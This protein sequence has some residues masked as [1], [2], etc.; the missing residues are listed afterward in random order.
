MATAAAGIAS[1]F[2]SS[3][4]TVKCLRSKNYMFAASSLSQSSYSYSLEP[5]SIGTTI[6][7]HKLW[8]PRITAA[9]AH[10]EAIVAA[11]E[12][13]TVVEEEKEGQ[14][15]VK[16][17]GGEIVDTRTKLY[18][19]NLPYGVDS[20]QLAGLIEDYGSA[21]LIEVLN[22]LTLFNSH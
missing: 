18:F 16:E 5:L 17:S 7:S 4:N 15:T 20:A 13:E 14:E 12:E 8:M 10:E 1:L 21:E 9:V 11:A 22:Y 19:G 6:S 2:S 3:I